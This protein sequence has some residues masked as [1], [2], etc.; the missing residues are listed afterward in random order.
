MLRCRQGLVD[1][2]AKFGA[3]DQ[4]RARR[5]L[6][7]VLV[8]RNPHHGV[9]RHRYHARLD[10]S[11]KGVNELGTVLDHHQRP[12][13]RLN[14]ERNQGISTATDPLGEFSIGDLFITGS[15][16]HL[17]GA[18]LFEMA[19]DERYGDI[20]DRRELDRR[21]AFAFI[22][23]DGIVLH[24]STQVL[25]SNFIVDIR[26]INGFPTLTATLSPHNGVWMTPRAQGLWVARGGG[27]A[28]NAKTVVFEQRL[29]QDLLSELTN[30]YR[31]FR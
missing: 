18:A 27:R 28:V 26:Q 24:G 11:E 5:I 8:V 17:A 13:A 6:D 3:V 19:V 21:R 25:P 2:V 9:D 23:C 22:Q 14:A 4:R 12:F 29:W 16:R 1:G 15:D 31:D 30:D 20:E 10:R 7:Q